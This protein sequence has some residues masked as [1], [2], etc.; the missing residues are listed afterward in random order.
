MDRGDS[1]VAKLLINIKSTI[2]KCTKVTECVSVC[3]SIF[4]PKDFAYKSTILAFL[5]R[6][7]S[8]LGPKRM[9]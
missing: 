4:M 9:R 3:L 6:E 7:A 8:F 1:K 5:F 2:L